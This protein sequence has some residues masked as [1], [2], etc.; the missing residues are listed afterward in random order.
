MRIK[1]KMFTTLLAVILLLMVMAVTVD[2]QSRHLGALK[3]NQIAAMQLAV[4]MLELRKHEKDFLAR[5]DTKYLEKF[6][7]GHRELDEG[8]SRLI[9]DLDEMSVDSSGISAVQQGIGNYAG[10]FQALAELQVQIGLNAA[11]GL[12]G[13]LRKAVHNA[14]SIFNKHTDYELQSNILMLR[15]IEKD[16]MLR[17]QTKY[18]GQFDKQVDVMRAVLSQSRLPEE[19]QVLAQQYIDKY[20]S[21]FLALVDAQKEIGLTHTA[22][23]LGRLRKS[24]HD[25][26]EDLASL[27][28]SLNEKIAKA[29]VSLK[30][31]LY[32]AMLAICLFI[33]ALLLWMGITIARRIR[34]A[35]QQM[36][37]IAEG[38]GDL[39]RRLVEHGGDELAD[40]AGAFNTFAGKVHDTLKKTSEL[41]AGLGQ[42]G[43]QLSSAASSTGISMQT[44]RTYTRSVVVATEEM[45]A[46]ARD[47]A[48][49]ASHVSSSAQQAD[50]VAAEG[51]GVVEQSI[52]SINSFANEFRE[53]AATITSLHS[54]TENIGGILDVIRGIAEQTNLLALNAAIE[55][56]RAG[57]QGRGFAVVAD[58]VRTLA[59]RSQQST[60]EIQ[61][62]IEGLQA[63]AESAS[64]VIQSSHERISDTVAQAEQAGVSLYNITESVRSISDM[65]TQIATAAEE[66]S[67]VVADINGNVVEI[68]SLA[69][70]TA[71]NADATTDLSADLAHTMAAVIRD[72]QKFRFENDEQLVLAQA[73]S[74]HLAWKGR[75][76]DFLDGKAHLTKAQ[77][78]SHHQCDLGKWYYSEGIKRFGDLADFKAI[79][80][81]HEHIHGLIQKVIKLR[82]EGD[83]DGAEAAFDE[84][85]QLS[86]EIVNDIDALAKKLL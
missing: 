68:D 72:M 48:N 6:V 22:G 24:V 83:L 8:F 30:W 16:F 2:Y 10:L 47:V 25:A 50:Q 4:G 65:T 40:L 38:D 86:V 41:V 36:Q 74:A 66:Q 3:D 32:M 82:A 70:Q 20:Q 18:I 57:E 19:D 49:N 34:A 5:R 85:S 64:T 53:A 39:S 44:L 62:L 13:N 67:V 51:Q 52:G 56:A 81:P 75:L 43:D 61:E 58:E 17:K 26:E 42:I 45:S 23:L 77:A 12:Y 69:E 80:R 54:E 55:A 21:D 14:E 29:E 71:K 27:S 59:H 78:V 7:T 79:E 60:N 33:G 35:S 1:T 76:R 9:T 15:R 73:K 46:T 84:I 31:T 28:V 11:S 37:Q 63:K